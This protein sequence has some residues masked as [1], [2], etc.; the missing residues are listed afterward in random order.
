MQWGHGQF[1][2]SDYKG[3]LL[4]EKYTTVIFDHSLNI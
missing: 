3:K 4:Q 1:F 2:K